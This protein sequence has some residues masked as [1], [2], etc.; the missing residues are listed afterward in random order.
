MN[1]E[2]LKDTMISIQQKLIDELSESVYDSHSQVDL[3][4]GDV[5]DPEDTSNQFVS[6]EMEAKVKA[7]L[8]KAKLDMDK[9]EEISFDNKST[10][11]PGAVVMTNK[12]NF[13]VG[14]AATPFD[15]E[16][17]HVVGISEDAPLYPQMSGKRQGESFSYQN[18]D[19]T[20]EKIY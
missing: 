15:F 12:G 18:N 5:I 4:E 14:F 13:I 11:E 8:T 1:K 16:G 10:V 9:L 7:Q 19:Y 2:S 20:I 3:D 17:M 6:G